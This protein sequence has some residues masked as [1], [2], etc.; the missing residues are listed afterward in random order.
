MGYLYQVIEYEPQPVLSA[1][2]VTPVGGL[3][4]AAGRIYGAIVSYLGELG[5]TIV[6][7]AFMAYYNMDMER[8]D[9]EIGFPVVHPVKGRGELKAGSI[10][11]GRRAVGYYKGPYTGMAD[12]YAGLEKWMREKD[13][14]PVGV[15]YEYYFNSP[16]E[17]SESELLTRVEFPVR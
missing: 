13:L 1:R 17:V 9:V 8:L 10:P 15:A 5:A 6:G 11:G 14:T 4:E 12:V 2:I 3:P 7:P 16:E